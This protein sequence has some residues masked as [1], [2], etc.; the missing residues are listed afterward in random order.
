MTTKKKLS[1][2]Y[3]SCG[4]APSRRLHPELFLSSEEVVTASTIATSSDNSSTPPTPVNS[5]ASSIQVDD[6]E[7]DDNNSTSY[8]S[9][10]DSDSDSSVGTVQHVLQLPIVVPTMAVSVQ[11]FIAP[12]IFSALSSDDVLDWLE[13]YEMAAIYNRWSNDDRARNFPMYLDGAAR[14]WFLVHTHPNH[15]ENLPI[16]PNP[17][18]PT[19]P[20]LPA[21]TGLKDQFTAAFKQANFSLVQESKIRQREQGNEEDVV[22]YF[23]DIVNICRMVNPAMSQEQQ[24]QYLYRGLKPTLFAKIYPLQPPTTVDFLELAKL[25]AEASIL[26]N[27]KVL[28]QSLLAVSQEQPPTTSQTTTLTD[29]VQTNLVTQFAGILNQLNQTMQGL[30]RPQNFISSGQIGQR[31]NNWNLSGRNK[32]TAEGRYICGFC[33]RIG[34]LDIKCFQNPNSP[35]FKNLGQQYRPIP[36]GKLEI[37][38]YH[39]HKH[40]N[41]ISSEYNINNVRQNFKS[42]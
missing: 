23:Y 26:V 30:Q 2:R 21:A 29:S 33:N 8:N 35:L 16:R 7:N 39:Y 25:H 17:A 6:S 12:P 31:Q 28:S 18:D 9:A 13:R 11:K 4:R 24:L 34:H 22:S 36:P 40:N 27:N 41:Q 42:I 15:W 14:K 1:S 3:P 10:E 19:L 20:Q 37:H 5:A 38:K 32:K